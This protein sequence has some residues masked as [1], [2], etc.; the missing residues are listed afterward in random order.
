ME[1]YR[2]Q[3]MIEAGYFDLEMLPNGGTVKRPWSIAF[4]NADQEQFEKNLQRLF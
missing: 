2:Y 3:V 1:N 4:E